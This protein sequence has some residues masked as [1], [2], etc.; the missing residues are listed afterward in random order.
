MIR[1][2][3]VDDQALTR[4]GLRMLC[5]TTDDIHIVAEADHGHK[6]VQA[7]ER[8]SPDLVL[9][10]LRMPGMD[11]ITAAARIRSSRP[12]VRILIL[13]TF[14][15]DDHLF[16]A[17]SAGADGF[18][19]K[20]AAPEDVLDGIRRVAAGD[21]VFSPAVMRRLVRAA[22]ETRT[23]VDGAIAG[24]ANLDKLT[25]REREVLA[26]VGEGLS[27][28]EIATRLHVG[29][30]T[31]KTHVGSLMTKTGTSNRVRLAVVSLRA[32]H[33]HRT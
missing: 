1:V 15:D 8:E 33:P 29:I 5:E 2:V 12:G 18:L 31:V 9:M 13:T 16:P 7:V 11:G 30:T 3:L 23:S 10:D 32:T 6:A 26:L 20:D 24:K 21:S 27:N 25:A 19:V 17:L 22:I 14:D 4:A 28:A